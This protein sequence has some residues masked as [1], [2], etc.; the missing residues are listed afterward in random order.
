MIKAVLL[1]I[2]IMIKGKDMNLNIINSFLFHP[3]KSHQEIGKNDF[4]IEVEDG[5]KV[6]TR[7]HLIS[8]SSPTILFFMVMEK[9][10][11]TMMI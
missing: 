8:Q 10:L 2:T 9:L 3:R 1:S 11:Q 7:L 6:G 4:F 5:V